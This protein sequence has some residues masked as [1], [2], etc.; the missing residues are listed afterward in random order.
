MSDGNF[1]L[2]IIELQIKYLGQRITHAFMA[3]QDELSAYVK[4]SVDA[5]FTSENIQAEVD[6]LCYDCM[7]ECIKEVFNAP[8][9]KAALVKIMIN[10]VLK[11]I[12]ATPE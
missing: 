7:Q 3:H 10:D 1:E 8:P 2:P 6:K 4:K 9:L 11:K 12:G 5:I